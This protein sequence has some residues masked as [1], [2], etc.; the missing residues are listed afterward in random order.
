ML[1]HIQIDESDA[2][3]YLTD[4]NHLVNMQM[5]RYNYKY[6][7]Q[8]KQFKPICS[9]NDDIKQFIKKD[10]YIFTFSRYLISRLVMNPLQIP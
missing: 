1:P 10:N 7:N 5:N 4:G 8:M 3:L 6:E 9:S 2:S